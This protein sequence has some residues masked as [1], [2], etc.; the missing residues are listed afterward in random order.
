VRVADRER[1]EVDL[2]ASWMPFHGDAHQPLVWLGAAEDGRA[3][4]A[5]VPAAQ[6][7]E[8][9]VRRGLRNLTFGRRGWQRARRIAV[10]QVD[11][12]DQ[13]DACCQQ[14]KG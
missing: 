13:T 4:R 7:V 12:A 11:P 3:V 2:Q 1:V 8:R 14:A 10:A 9:G 6:L 5:A